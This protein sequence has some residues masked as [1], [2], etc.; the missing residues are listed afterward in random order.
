MPFAYFTADKTTKLFYNLD[1][2]NA[3]DK[4][5]MLR[6]RQIKISKQKIDPNDMK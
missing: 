2:F 1:L 6:E 3:K 4:V 5:Q